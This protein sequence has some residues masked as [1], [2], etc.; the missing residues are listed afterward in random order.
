MLPEVGKA[1]TG[2]SAVPWS[3]AWRPIFERSSSRLTSVGS[4]L[5]AQA[6][7]TLA[8]VRPILFDVAVRVRR[9]S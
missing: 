7:V 8:T 6:I 1:A 3:R 4:G 2:V 9:D 5:I